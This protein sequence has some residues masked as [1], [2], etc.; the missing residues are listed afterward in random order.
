MS[1]YQACPRCGLSTSEGG[2]V[3]PLCIE[4]D[5]QKELEELRRENARLREAIQSIACLHIEYSS[6]FKFWLTKTHAECA[7]TLANDIEV[8]RSALEKK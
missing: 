2:A 5:Q 1:I 7:E 6:D 8:A 4:E 3:C